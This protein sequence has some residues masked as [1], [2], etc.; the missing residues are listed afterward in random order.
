M[1]AVPVIEVR[2]QALSDNLNPPPLGGQSRLILVAA[3][4]GF[5]IVTLD[6]LAVN[7]ALPSIHHAFG[8]GISGLQWVVDAYT[9]AFAGLLLWAGALSDRVGA[10][11]AF[12]AGAGMF[13]AASA[14]CGL[15][16]SLGWLVTAR[17]VQ[18]SAAA[19]L[20][21]A[22]MALLSHAFPEGPDRARAV[23]LWAMGGVAASTSGPLL[24]GL[25]TLVSWRLIFFINLPA[26]AA[27]V[28]LAARMA[29]SPRRRASFDWAGQLTG[30]AAMGALTYGAIQAG[31]AGFAAP[32][33]LAGFAVAVVSLAGFLA[34]EARAAHP[35]VPLGLFRSRNISVPVGVG[36]AFVVGFY[37]LP[38][39][40]SLYLQ[41]VRH[42]SPF[43]TGAVFVPMALLGGV[44]TPFSARLAERIGPRT[45]IGGG[46]TVMA[47]GL[48]LLAVVSPTAP[49]WALALL[50]VPVG[51]AGP[52]VMPPVTAVLLNSVPGQQA[53][54]VSGVFNTSRQVGGALAV[55]VF[56]ALLTRQPDLASGLRTSLLVAAAVALGA[57]A[58]T[59]LLAS[60]PHPAACL[61][62]AAG[63]V[64]A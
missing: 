45:V 27:A 38:F 13:A 4:I 48:A 36:F 21:P 6:A 28:V 25:L 20:M 34:V 23:G 8:G 42:L 19:V 1:A 2:H 33:V 26:G 18:G 16:P 22:S 59:G 58:T 43:A 57:M 31:A 32:Q 64:A 56:G 44:L 9:L 55:A 15:A 30:V 5:F 60:R 29:P 46:L 14:A 11:R 62:S 10:S 12:T 7:V 24:G 37:G 47:V 50:M 39:V 61:C 3:V 63:G 53:G 54:T 52:A 51:L 35:M 49:T 41:Q 40:M 17:F